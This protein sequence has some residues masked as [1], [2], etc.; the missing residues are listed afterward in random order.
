[1]KWIQTCEYNLA[2]RPLK[3]SSSIKLHSSSSSRSQSSH[4]SS[5]SLK[6]FSKTIVKL[7]F[8]ALNSNIIKMA[9]ISN[10]SSNNNNN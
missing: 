8:L 4:R 5:H 1:M 6:I 3:R 2:T 9:Y 7:D 10:S